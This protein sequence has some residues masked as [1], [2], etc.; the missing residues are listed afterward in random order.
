[1]SGDTKLDFIDYYIPRRFQAESDDQVTVRSGYGERLCWLDGVNQ[2]ETVI[3]LLK[4]RPTSRRAVIQL[5]RAADLEKNYASIPCTCTLQFL[6][7]DGLLHMF[8]SMRSNDAYV[9]LPHDVFAFT[10]L[11]EL[12]ARS[13]GL[14]VG[15]YKH[16]AGSLHLYEADVHS[17]MSYVQEG[18]QATV[19]M[20]T[21]PLGD[22]WRSLHHLQ[23]LEA[24]IRLD[25]PADLE[26]AC[27]EEYWKDLARL[28][29]AFKASKQSDAPRLAIL[30]SE[31]SS[32]VYNI[33]LQARLDRV[34]G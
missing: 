2:L 8:V 9:G 27:L 34:A 32:E 20:P 18:W 28:L 15:E 30:K 16:F 23:Q 6:A 11:Q 12:V 5:F 26:S 13:V 4:E 7:R 17:A 33:F 31:M 10:M 1:M 19:V 14:E 25:Q 24:A 3:A 21:M 29:L 22:P